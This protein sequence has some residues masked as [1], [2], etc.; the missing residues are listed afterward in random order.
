[1]FA[2]DLR[3]KHLFVVSI[4]Q[5]TFSDKIYRVYIARHVFTL[6]AEQYD[7]ISTKTC[8]RCRHNNGLFKSRPVLRYDQSGN[9]PL[10]FRC[11]SSN[12]M[13]TLILGETNLNLPFHLC[14]YFY[15]DQTTEN[16]VCGVDSITSPKIVNN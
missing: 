2:Y 13:V 3:E 10:L 7:C 1:M 9:N 12:P 14:V 16:M 8:R 4:K 15:R 11:V 6:I 5:N